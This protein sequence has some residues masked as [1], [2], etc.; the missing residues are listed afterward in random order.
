MMES[1]KIEWVYSDDNIPNIKTYLRVSVNVRMPDRLKH[2]LDNIER[3]YRKIWVTLALMFKINHCKHCERPLSWYFSV[4]ET[5][6]RA[7]RGMCNRY[8]SEET[9]YRHCPDDEREAK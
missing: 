6:G 3:S 2:K 4:S 7:N 8:E 1:N 5:D 9:H